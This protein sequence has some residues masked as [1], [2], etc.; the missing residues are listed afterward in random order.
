MA[1][2]ADPTSSPAPD[3]PAPTSSTMTAADFSRYAALIDAALTP[4][5]E[6]I[7]AAESATA[8]Q[9]ERGA[10]FARA[11]K[12]L[13]TEGDA[14][15]VDRLIEIAPSQRIGQLAFVDR[16]GHHRPLYRPLMFYGWL[17]TYRLRFETLPRL[18]FGRWDEAL[19][20]WCDLL[21]AELET[22]PIN[23]T[24]TP[25]SRGDSASESAWTALALHVAGKVFVRD[26]WTDLAA[27]LFGR[28]S[29][30]QLDNGAFLTASSSDNPETA[31]YHELTLLHAAGSYAVQAEDRTVARAV[32]RSAAHLFAE[33][34]PDHATEQ[35]WGLFPFI[36]SG[37]ST[38]PMADQQLHAV[39]MRSPLDGVS[40]ILLADTLYCLRLFL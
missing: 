26:A 29:R 36:W 34:Q 37:R 13:P 15:F 14:P 1:D 31:W 33:V 35:P 27:D 32:A 11:I 24:G 6:F 25:A 9:V 22:I 12:N 10:V 30:G 16:A 21:E 20:L 28:L 4:P 3:A 23:E 17:N 7:P 8:L 2:T 19:R 18:E 38:Q 5:D 39:S 40:L